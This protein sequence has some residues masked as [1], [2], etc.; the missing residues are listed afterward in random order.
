M[1][2]EAA[3]RLRVL[4]SSWTVADS[5]TQGPA[6]QKI[7]GRCGGD[8]KNPYAGWILPGVSPGTVVDIMPMT[9]GLC[10][11]RPAVFIA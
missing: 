3:I 5:R 11:F 8:P 7:M 6:A 1:L 2:D 10:N 9:P 4:S